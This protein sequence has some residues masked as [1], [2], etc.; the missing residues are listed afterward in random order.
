MSAELR[1]RDE[2]FIERMSRERWAEL[3]KNFGKVPLTLGGLKINI[4][5][6]SETFHKDLHTYIKA[7]DEAFRTTGSTELLKG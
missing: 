5:G 2:I 7:V 4:D 3:V 6:P 1:I